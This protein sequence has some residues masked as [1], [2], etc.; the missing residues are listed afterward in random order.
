MRLSAT[1][2]IFF[3]TISGTATAQ[4][5][6]EG[7]YAGGS[8]AAFSGENTYANPDG[9][10][11][12]DLEGDMLGAFAGY[13]ALFNGFILGGELAFMAGAANEEGFADQ[14]EYGSVIDIKGKVGLDADELMPYLILGASIG[15]LEVDEEGRP[16]RNFDQ[17]ETGILIGAGA[18][19][20]INE[21]FS[22]G[23]ELVSRQFEFDFGD[24]PLVDME[25]TVNSFAVRG[26]YRF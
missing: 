20:S 23:A 8:F 3:T 26:L 13:N 24:I 5:A 10:L 16:D 1:I 2:L 6:W 17:T 12:F 25:A 19:F 22:V 9:D 4:T 21:Q 7:F 11:G 14:Y 18:D 15:A